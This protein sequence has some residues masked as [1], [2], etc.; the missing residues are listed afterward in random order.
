VYIFFERIEPF[1][2]NTQPVPPL[3]ATPVERHPPLSRRR[4]YAHTFSA[5]RH[6][7]LVRGADGQ[8]RWRVV[9][10][11]AIVHFG[12]QRSAYVKWKGSSFKRKTTS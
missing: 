2:R 5:G 4:R 12:K 8:N 11:G 1:D 10:D 3:P 9:P 7:K 6:L